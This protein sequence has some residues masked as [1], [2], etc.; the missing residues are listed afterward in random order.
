MDSFIQILLFL[1]T[2]TDSYQ[3]C[4]KV[5]GKK[6]GAAFSSKVSRTYE[7]IIVKINIVSNT[8][9]CSFPGISRKDVV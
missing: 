3:L 7:Q 6:R 1:V 2:P 4:V 8:I 9:I 5:G